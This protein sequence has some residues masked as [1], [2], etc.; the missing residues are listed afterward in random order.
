MDFAAESSITKMRPKTM[1]DGRHSPV[2]RLAM[3]LGGDGL[4]AHAR[5]ALA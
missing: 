1:T 4:I 3:G 2:R 5:K